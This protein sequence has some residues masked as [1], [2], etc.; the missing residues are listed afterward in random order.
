VIQQNTVTVATLGP[1]AF[2]GELALLKAGAKRS[3]GVRAR[4]EVE[5]AV[6]S[7]DGFEVQWLWQWL[8]DSGS[9]SGLLTV[10]VAGWQWQWLSDSGSVAG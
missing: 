3:A 7:R 6:L 4:G 1:G 8:G 9:G 2:F 5:A 10:A